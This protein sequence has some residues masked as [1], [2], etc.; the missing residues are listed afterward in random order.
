MNR[1]L[2]LDFRNLDTN[3][4]NP[5]NLVNLLYYKKLG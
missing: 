4:G 3:Q 2:D 5:A 1:L